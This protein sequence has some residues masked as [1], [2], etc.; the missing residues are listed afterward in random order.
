[1]YVCL[2][3]CVYVCVLSGRAYG[4]LTYAS[5]YVC[6]CVCMV[7]IC[8]C[9]C[10]Y[11]VYMY[12]SCPVGRMG[13][14]HM[15]LCMYVCVYVW[16]VYV[17]VSSGGAYE[18][19]IQESANCQ[20]KKKKVCICRA[21]CPV[22]RTKM[23]LFVLTCRHIKRIRQREAS[24]PSQSAKKILPKKIPNENKILPTCQQ[25]RQKEAPRPSQS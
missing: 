16:C 2:C 5:V 18:D 19:I 17:C 13:I 1:M 8:M 23:C 9:V 6:V 22:W 7:C 12:V 10:M 14:L 20:R 24:G 15:H 4:D 21:C 11:G 3:M 25:I